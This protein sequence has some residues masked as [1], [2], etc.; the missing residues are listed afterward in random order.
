M[1]SP[2]TPTPEPPGWW[3]H[4]LR[5]LRRLFAPTQLP[6]L[7]PA[8]NAHPASTIRSLDDGDRFAAELLS[9][10]ATHLA[11]ESGG[12]RQELEA[13]LLARRGANPTDSGA[14]GIG[15]VECSITK[16]SPA[17][18]TVELRVLRTSGAKSTLLTLKRETG[19]DD[20]PGA[21]RSAFIH[22]PTKEQVFLLIEGSIPDSTQPT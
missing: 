10:L 16:S 5:W 19:W 11:R 3:E 20:L 1:E 8:P 2:S 18:A 22:S 17:R 9:D 21:V 12:N 15:R 6:A 14:A 4:L 13:A 7:Q